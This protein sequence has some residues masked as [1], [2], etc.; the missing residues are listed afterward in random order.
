MTKWHAKLLFSTKKV[1]GRFD[2]TMDFQSA[3]KGKWQSAGYLYWWVLSRA[4]TK[5][6]MS[7]HFLNSNAQTIQRQIIDLVDGNVRISKIRY[8]HFGAILEI[9]NADLDNVASL[10]LHTPSYT[11]FYLGG[12]RLVNLTQSSCTVLSINITTFTLMKFKTLTVL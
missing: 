10:L 11:W 7:V 3:I 4:C 1:N 5:R 8:Q 2:F 9:L 6:C 12:L